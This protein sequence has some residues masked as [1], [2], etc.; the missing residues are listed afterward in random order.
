M[1][2]ITLVGIAAGAASALL[3]AS[4]ASGS[5]FSV[6]LFYVAPLPIL[7]AALGWSHVAGLIAAVAAAA[8]LAFIFGGVFFAAFLIGIGLPAWWLGY[9]ALLARPTAPGGALEWYP[10]GHL[11]AWA[12][13]LAALMVSAVIFSFGFDFDG[14]RS[15]L[16]RAFDHVLRIQ[17]DTP[18][19]APLHVPGVADPSRLIDLMVAIIPPTAAVLA[20]ITN[21]VNLWLAAR[22]VKTSHRL[23]RPWPDLASSRPFFRA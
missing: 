18:A 9:L 16:R 22:V 6:L 2:H 8:T 20:T 14:F 1:I 5:L 15:G 21:L 11:V 4:L 23:R 7:I 13:L 10:V 12:A 17:T 19:D 3:F